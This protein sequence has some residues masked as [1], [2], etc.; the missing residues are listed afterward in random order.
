MKRNECLIVQLLIFFLLAVPCASAGLTDQVTETVLPNGL[1]V[2]LLENHKAP[3]VTFQVWYRVGSSNEIPGK[4]GLSH[5][6]EHM[7]FKGTKKV[8]PEMFSRIIQENGGNNNAFT[9]HDYTAY[10]ENLRSD[11]VQ[12]AIDLEADRMRNLV[13]REKDFRTERKV[14]MEERRQRT[15]DNPQA[16]LWERVEAAAFTVSPYRWPIIGWMEDMERWTLGDLTSHYRTYYSPANAFLV[17]AGDFNRDELL[18]RIR[19]AFGSLP[20]GVKPDE[21]RAQEP[22]QKEERRIVVEKEAQLPFLVKGY[23]VPNLHDPDSYVLE[24]IAAVLSGGKSSRFYS[25]LVRERRLALE[26]ETDHSLLSLDPRLFYLYAVPMPGRGAEELE[27][28]LDGEMEKL[29]KELVGDEELQRAK[30]QI[31]ASFVF[32]QDSLFSQAAILARHEIVGG[33][34]KLED[35]LPAIRKVTAEDIRRVAAAYLVRGNSTVGILVPQGSKDSRG[36][37]VK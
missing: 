11:R 23:H 12:A 3:L 18:P 22:P 21:K 30:N 32:G 19:K 33:W 36:Q 28:A 1:K 9:S 5:M 20:G 26:A 37:G 2:I 10:Y 24:V 7:M 34:K 17:V 31:E 13:L 4:T 6:L 8:G 16:Y 27:K 29:R 15:E 14:V 25:G 35:Y